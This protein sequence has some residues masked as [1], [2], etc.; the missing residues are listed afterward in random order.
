M[1]AGKGFIIQDCQNA[2]C[3]CHKVNN[4]QAESQADRDAENQNENE[5]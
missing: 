3:E 4:F 2:N 1:A 5:N